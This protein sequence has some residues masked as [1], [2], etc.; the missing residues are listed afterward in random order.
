VDHCA[1]MAMAVCRPDRLAVEKYT[2]VG[3]EAWCA[4]VRLRC[5]LWKIKQATGELSKL[6]HH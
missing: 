2:A 6:S 5:C 4:M 3:T 1:W